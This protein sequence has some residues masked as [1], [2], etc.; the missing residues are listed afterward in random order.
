[1]ALGRFQINSVLDTASNPDD[2]VLLAAPGANQA[3]YI[4]WLDVVVTTAEAATVVAIE[5][6]AGGTRLASAASTA[7]GTQTL[8]SAPQ[9][10]NSGLKLTDNTALNATTEGGTSVAANVVGEVVV[11][12]G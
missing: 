9:P 4:Q 10:G 12:G 1:M 2:T 11:R 5:D 3:I 6:G 7:V 8:V